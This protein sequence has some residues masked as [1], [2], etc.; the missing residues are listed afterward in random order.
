MREGGKRVGGES[1]RTR[2]ERGKKREARTKVG[3]SMARVI[4]RRHIRNVRC[5]CER[6]R[7]EWVER[8]GGAW[9]KREVQLG[10]PKPHELWWMNNGTPVH[11]NTTIS[12][13]PL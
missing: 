12:P 8:D 2:V 5:K 10:D 7:K 6:K 4:A 3:Y 9:R 1:I 11:R 13:I